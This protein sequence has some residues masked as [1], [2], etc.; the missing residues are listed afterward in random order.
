LS[1]TGKGDSPEN[2]EKFN[3]FL[4]RETNNLDEK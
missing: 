2:G 4:R 3:R 1:S